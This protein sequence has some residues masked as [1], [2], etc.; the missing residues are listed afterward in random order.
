[1]RVKINATHRA[2]K[3][4]RQ[5]LAN[6]LASQP[7]KVITRLRHAVLFSLKWRCAAW[8]CHAIRA[9][10]GMVI[11]PNTNGCSNQDC[12]RRMAI[13]MDTRMIASAEWQMKRRA[14]YIWDSKKHD[15]SLW[16]RF[17]L[18]PKLLTWNLIFSTLALT[19]KSSQTVK[20]R[21]LRW[22]ETNLQ[23]YNWKQQKKEDDQ[24]EYACRTRW[25]KDR[26]ANLCVNETGEEITCAPTSS[27]S[28][29]GSKTKTASSAK[30]DLALAQTVRDWKLLPSHG[31]QSS[32]P[33]W[34]RFQK[35]KRWYPDHRFEAYTFR[36]ISFSMRFGTS[37]VTPQ[38]SKRPV[39]VG[40]PIH[41]QR[42][43]HSC[44]NI[45]ILRPN[46]EISKCWQIWF[47]PC[48]HLE[49]QY[50]SLINPKPPGR[51]AQTMGTNPVWPSSTDMT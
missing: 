40:S 34:N 44:I 2:S 8:A 47:V 41:P 42:K 43:P 31:T 36:S 49:D 24:E 27:S 45:N 19:F 4:K 22:I 33:P 3:R 14:V 21:T 37:R 32:G 10:A 50:T 38:P 30:L 5:H 1:M 25:E 28:G 46:L 17:S 23:L 16:L 9:C 7:T 29:K 48:P 13:Q 11:F 39:A 26:F 15:A 12:F 35:K 18:K 20:E 51:G 6:Q